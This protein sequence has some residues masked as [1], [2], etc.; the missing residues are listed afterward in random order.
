MSGPATA[1]AADAAAGSGGGLE[2]HRLRG[3]GVE[4]GVIAHGARIAAVRAPDR[5][6]RWA[7]VALGLADLAAYRAD[8]AYLGACV[9]HYANR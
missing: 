2:V 6:G 3:S 9:G 1:G 4:V 8:P 5:S 7:E